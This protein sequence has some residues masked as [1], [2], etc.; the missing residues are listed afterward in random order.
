MP[1]TVVTLRE[2]IAGMIPSLALGRWAFCSVDA[3]QAATLLPEAVAL[4]REAEGLS[5]IV[6]VSLAPPGAVAMRQITLAVH[7][8][9]EGVG[10]TAAVL[11]ALA[12]EGIACNIVAACL[13]DHIFVP[14]DQA[15]A[16]MAR[17][18]ALQRSGQGIDQM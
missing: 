10:L 11:Q 1:Q 16:A 18:Q 17:L 13:H 3:A 2:M 15:A 4:F 9:L 7:S 8:S 5:L 12:E 6:P 14:E